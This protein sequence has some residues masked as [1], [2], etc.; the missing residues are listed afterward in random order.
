MALELGA[1]S[2]LRKPFT[3]VVLMSVVTE[4]LAESRSRHASIARQL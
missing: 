3:P 1:M 2:C 4:C